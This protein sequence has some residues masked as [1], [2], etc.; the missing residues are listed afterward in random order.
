M[1]KV[2]T[3]RPFLSTNSKFCEDRKPV[4]TITLTQI[5]KTHIPICESDSPQSMTYG[6]ILDAQL[7]MAAHEGRIIQD[8]SFGFEAEDWED[9]ATHLRETNPHFIPQPHD[10]YA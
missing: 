6:E 2:K 3:P 8:V 1:R 9:Y 10:D 7:L 5:V 4:A